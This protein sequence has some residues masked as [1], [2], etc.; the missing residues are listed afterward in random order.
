MA[1]DIWPTIH[2]ERKA[3]ADDLSGSDASPVGG[4]VAVR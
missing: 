1:H 3:L 4:S 2:A